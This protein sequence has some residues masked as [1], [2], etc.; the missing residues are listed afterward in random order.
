MGGGGGLP[1]QH[2][3]LLLKVYGC[4]TANGLPG[5]KWLQR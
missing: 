2:L 4:P 3:D 5:E 1:E